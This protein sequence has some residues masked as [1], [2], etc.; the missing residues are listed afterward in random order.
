[1]ILPSSITP[2]AHSRVKAVVGHELLDTSRDLGRLSARS[3]SQCSQSSQLLDLLDRLVLP[4]NGIGNRYC[5]RAL[6]ER[7][8][9]EIRVVFD[10]QGAMAKRAAKTKA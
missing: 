8:A 6:N 1:M 10:A 5:R 2:G 3:D 4:G 9:S 7:P